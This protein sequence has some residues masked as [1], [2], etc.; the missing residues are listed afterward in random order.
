V[1]WAQELLVTILPRLAGSESVNQA[2][3]L[4][5][6]P[7][8]RAVKNAQPEA[9]ELLLLHGAAVGQDGGRLMRA[10]A[11][12]ASRMQQIGW[13]LVPISAAGVEARERC[14]LCLAAAGAAAPPCLQNLLP[15][16]G[17]YAPSTLALLL[18]LGLLDNLEEQV[19][20]AHETLLLYLLTHAC[21]DLGLH[22]PGDHDGSR[23]RASLVAALLHGTC[24]SAAL[25]DLHAQGAPT[26]C[27][28]Y[29]FH[30]IFS[31]LAV[32]SPQAADDQGVP[33]LEQLASKLCR[34]T[35]LPGH[36]NL[37]RAVLA[38]GSLPTNLQDTLLLDRSGTLRRML[39]P[40]VASFEIV[41]R[42][43]PSRP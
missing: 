35:G 32:Y 4:G 13:N 11:L 42:S 8:E 19:A 22:L 38:N 37:W 3:K 20:N 18:S 14:L 39:L 1:W 24:S 23:V 26:T 7:L 29:A 36:A 30:V 33:R 41:R 25:A 17:L 28:G 2:N 43:E 9:V 12:S 40:L 27:A 34:R 31:T 16:C 15:D 5:E 10:C 21:N 6:T